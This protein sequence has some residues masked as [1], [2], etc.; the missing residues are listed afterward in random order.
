[1]ETQTPQQP[2]R[3]AGLCKKC[4]EFRFGYLM[5]GVGP[6]LCYQ[7]ASNIRGA[8]KDSVT[9][10][11]SFNFTTSNSATTRTNFGSCDN[12]FRIGGS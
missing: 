11:W 7:C 1:M 6:F 12:E 10:V 5:H 8:E 4:H 2:L 9:G 3:L